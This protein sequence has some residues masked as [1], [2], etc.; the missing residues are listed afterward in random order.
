MPPTKRKNAADPKKKAASPSASPADAPKGAETAT[1]KR[2]KKG[3]KKQATDPAMVVTALAIAPKE[4]ETGTQYEAIS[5]AKAKE[6]K[7]RHALMQRQ[8]NKAKKRA[9][10]EPAN[11][12]KCM[13]A[14]SKLWD[15]QAPTTKE[16]MVKPMPKP[17]SNIIEKAAAKVGDF[18]HVKRDCSPGKWRFGGEGIIQAV[19]GVGGRT[20][21]DVRA[22]NGT[23][24]GKLWL[25][26]EINDFTVLPAV[27]DR[28]LAP[29]K[30]KPKGFSYVPPPLSLPLDDVTPAARTLEESLIHGH[31]YNMGVGFRR[32]EVMGPATNLKSR[33]T[34]LEKTTCYSDVKELKQ[35]RTRGGTV[36]YAGGQQTTR[37][38]GGTFAATSGPGALTLEFLL[39]VGWGVSVNAASRFSK[40]SQSI[41]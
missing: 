7:R 3:P 32:K 12:A 9:A 25:D 11:A 29:R 20:K 6:I 4:G 1:K 24:M 26:V 30:C 16:E 2:R 10:E 17:V 34:L 31:R 33:L 39:T 35:I 40:A 15:A 28:K 37:S 22:K 19:R 23:D 36:S 14:M 5:A 18:V 13:A 8:A 27:Q 38:K 21:I 41:V